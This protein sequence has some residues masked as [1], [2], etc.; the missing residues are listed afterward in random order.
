MS[1]CPRLYDCLAELSQHE[2]DGRELQERERPAVPGFDGTVLA[3]DG[4]VVVVVV[5]INYRLNL[6]GYIRLDDC[7]S[8]LTD[9]P[10]QKRFK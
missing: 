2:A 6:F 5:T 9:D 3:R 8:A 10:F 4:D 1:V 7:R